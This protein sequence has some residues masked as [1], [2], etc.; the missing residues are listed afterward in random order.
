MREVS[1]AERLT[2]LAVGDKVLVVKN[3]DPKLVSYV[4]KRGTVVGSITPFSCRVKLVG[5][6]EYYFDRRELEKQ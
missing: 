4:G 1:P 3:T 2:P 5:G 6:M